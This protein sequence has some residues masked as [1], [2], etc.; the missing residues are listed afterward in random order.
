MSKVSLNSL[1]QIA[2]FENSLCEIYS[3]TAGIYCFI[4]PIKN[5]HFSLATRS[6]HAASSYRHKFVKLILIEFPSGTEASYSENNKLMR[7]LFALEKIASM[8]YQAGEL[9]IPR[10]R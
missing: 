5:R 10:E 2:I 3:V 6:L 1:Y 4:E 9:H 7:S 8:R